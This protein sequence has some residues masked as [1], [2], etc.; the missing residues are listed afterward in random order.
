LLP[1]ACPEPLCFAV[2][3]ALLSSLLLLSPLW[4]AV[5]LSDVRGAELCAACDDA[6]LLSGSMVSMI[7]PNLSCV[8]R[9]VVVLSSKQYILCFT[10]SVNVVQS[11]RKG[12]RD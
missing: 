11:A 6:S 8:G 7:R 4:V 2:V 3:E 1:E 10:E 9:T 5:G 12:S